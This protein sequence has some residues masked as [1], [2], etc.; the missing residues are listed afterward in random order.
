MIISYIS[1]IAATLSP[2]SIPLPTPTGSSE[3]QKIR[4]VIQQKVKDKIEEI[5]K[6]DVVDP[7][8][9]I[10]GI[11]KEISPNSLTVSSNNED[12]IIGYDIDTVIIGAKLTKIKVTD[13]KV[14]QEILS[15]GIQSADSYL[16]KRILVTSIKNVTNNFSILSGNIIDISESSPII[17][18]VPVTDKNRQS[19]LKYDIKKLEIVDK[20]G[21]KINFD[22]LKVGQKVAVLYNLSSQNDQNILITKLIAL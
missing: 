11:I 19:Q 3:I 1:L 2:T 7:K 5:T 8:K 17:L 14:G 12:Q 10:L 16:A 4:E 13:L 21:K 6:S 20:L 9:S 18:I 15:L 22:T